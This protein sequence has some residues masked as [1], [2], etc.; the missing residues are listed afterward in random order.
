[1]DKRV[2]DLEG[3]PGGF[4]DEIYETKIF[5]VNSIHYEGITQKQWASIR[6]QTARN[7]F[8]IEA[9]A[10]D[11]VIEGISATDKRFI[12][13]VQAHF[14]LEGPLHEALFGLFFDKITQYA[15]L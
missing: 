6:N 4:M 3:Q 14:E 10:P 13:G 5:P 15:D 7:I 2:H 12:L 1:M 8:R 9:L 11:G